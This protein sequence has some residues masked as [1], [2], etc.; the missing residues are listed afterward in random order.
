MSIVHE[1]GSST[2]LT[3]DPS[4]GY[5]A[6]AGTL[7]AGNDTVYSNHYSGYRQVA[8]HWVPATISIER[9][10][11]FSNRLLSS[12]VWTIT[13]V[14]AT[15]P[16]PGSFSVD[17]NADTFIEYRSPATERTAKYLYSH[18]VDTDKLLADRL[19]YAASEGTD[20]Q[21]CA[22]AA[23]A[24]VAS[25]LGRPVPGDMLAS[26]VGPNGQT[27]MRDMKQ[28]AGA[29]GLF[30]RAVRTDLPALEALAGARAI[31]HLPGKNHFVVLDSVDDRFVRLIDVSNDTFYYRA[32]VDFF[33]MEWSGGVAL[34]I[35]TKPIA[36]SFATI[37][38]AALQAMVGD[39]GW[40]CTD[41]LQE[42]DW[43]TCEAGCTGWYTVWEERWG[44]EPAPSGT[45][46]NEWLIQW[47]ETECYYNVSRRCVV[48]G[49][50]DCYYMLACD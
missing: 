34:L 18:S 20:K 14:D 6:T 48:T 47:R 4:K 49:E 41:L 37:D 28:L 27:T 43:Q 7:P 36:G 25:E 39:S 29:L 35:G 1:D 23:F 38:E 15:A 50:W 21:N 40:S 11:A 33:P 13:S 12:D 31:L 9:R 22:T 46:Y 3:L 45:C 42:W 26:I 17:F 2:D 30:A 10:E 16:S 32:A 5:A 19:A 24:H 8:G 44:C